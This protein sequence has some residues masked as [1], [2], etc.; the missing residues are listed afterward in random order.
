[1]LTAALLLLLSACSWQPP[2]QQATDPTPTLNPEQK[3]WQTLA[4]RPLSLAALAAGATCPT[5]P[6]VPHGGIGEAL[7]DGPVYVLRGQLGL[8][9]TLRGPPPSHFGSEVWGGDSNILALDPALR[10]L[11]LVRGAQLD[12]TNDVG[13]G[14][15]S[16]SSA[17]V[18][19]LIHPGS[20]GWTRHNAFTRVRAPGCYAYQVDGIR[21]QGSAMFTQI[22][23]FIATPPS[24]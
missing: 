7:G 11:V 24:T 22:I 1:M 2:A 5:G 15:R 17:N 9:A 14:D 3:A 6:G 18:R 20:D 19:V 10:G 8:E 21:A 12:G 13:V 23:V 4:R 16:V